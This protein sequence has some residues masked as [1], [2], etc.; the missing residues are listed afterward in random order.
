LGKSTKNGPGVI[1]T[2]CSRMISAVP[3][4]FRT[5][6]P[7]AEHLLLP[8]LPSQ[9]P[10]YFGQPTFNA[11]LNGDI[12]HSMRSRATVIIVTLILLTCLVCP[13]VEMFDHWDHT[14]QTGNDTEYALV[15]LALC[16]GAAYSFARYIFQS[17][18]VRS[19]V[20]FVPDLFL[21]KPHPCFSSNSLAVIPFSTSPPLSLRI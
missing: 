20:G 1:A 15:V 9:F 11:S 19:A 12:I 21:S 5:Y 10:S 17:P 3:Q 13:L 14:C 18:L 4:D 6:E 2:F 16:I 8:T 7:T